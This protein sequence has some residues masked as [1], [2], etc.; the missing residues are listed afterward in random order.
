MTFLAYFF[1][2]LIT[3]FLLGT[4]TLMITISICAIFMQLRKTNTKLWMDNKAF[5]L[6]YYWMLI[7]P[8]LSAIIAV[9]LS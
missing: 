5:K 6:V 4:F 7:C 8:I 3:L 9:F 1:V 2:I